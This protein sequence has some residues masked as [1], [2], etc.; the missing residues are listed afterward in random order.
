MRY[1]SLPSG[2][3]QNEGF[4]NPNKPHHVCRLLK[5]LYSLKQ[6][7]HEWNHT[8]NTHL[9]DNNFKPTVTN[10]CIYI[11]QWEDHQLVMIAIYINDCTIITPKHLLDKTKNMLRQH[12]KM[13]DLGEAESVLGIEIHQD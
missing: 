1:I 8:L 4:V 3:L 10:L 2:D 6:A 12:F 11:H 7:L 5:S 13:K 9:C